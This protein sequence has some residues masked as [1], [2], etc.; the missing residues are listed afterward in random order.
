MSG[1]RD[2]WLFANNIIRSSRQLVNEGL[3][4]LGLSSAEGNILIH[5]LT[6]DRVMRQEELVEQLEV[7]KPA[8]SRALESLERK[9]YVK[10]Q[11]DPS[12]QRANQVTLT[13]KARR[14]GADVERVYDKVFSI[15]AQV[16]TEEAVAGF[17]RVF[18]RVSDSFSA[19][20]ANGKSPVSRRDV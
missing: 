12:D 18:G 9:G 10:R 16:L 2:V 17:I 1:I 5:L 4:P 19:A 6:Q 20:Q 11:R 15:A 7:T 3:K 8:V 14:I 13:D